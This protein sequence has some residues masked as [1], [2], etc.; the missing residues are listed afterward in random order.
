VKQRR[1]A[2]VLDEDQPD[3]HQHGSEPDHRASSC[4]GDHLIC[5][6]T[7][8]GVGRLSNGRIRTHRDH[9]HFLRTATVPRTREENDHVSRADCD[10][11]TGAFAQ[12]GAWNRRR[13]W[14]SAQ[15]FAAQ[16][17]GTNIVQRARVD[18]GVTVDR[19]HVSVVAVGDAALVVAEPAD[20]G[21]RRG[22]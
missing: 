1:E 2:E 16:E 15:A 7:T 9:L 18:E 22:G 20:H 17:H 10:A 8:Q 14:C 13:N 12:V 5:D 21:A 19:E 4:H 6:V 11:T 3:Q